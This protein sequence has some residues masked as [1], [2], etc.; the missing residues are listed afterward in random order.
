M[1]NSSMALDRH[2]PLPKMNAPFR[3]AFMVGPATPAPAPAPVPAA[4]ATIT[5]DDFKKVVLKSGKVIEATEH[6]N[7][8]KLLVLKVD[9][10]GGDV[11]QIVSGIKQWY[12]PAQL[13]GKT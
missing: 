13:V 2:P 5:I 7:A 6:A 3:R 9:L 12:A 10:G 8:N 1:I 11:R 4:P